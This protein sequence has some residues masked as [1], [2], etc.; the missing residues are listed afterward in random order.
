MKENISVG[1]NEDAGEEILR[2]GDD[3]TQGFGTNHS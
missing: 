1:R 2:G 3:K